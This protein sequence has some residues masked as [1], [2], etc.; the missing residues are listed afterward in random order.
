M[1]PVR[2]RSRSRTVRLDS[3]WRRYELEIAEFLAGTC[4]VMIQFTIA[5]LATYLASGKA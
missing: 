2:I 5:L 1:I 4:V 3:F